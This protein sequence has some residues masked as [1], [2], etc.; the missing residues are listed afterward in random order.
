MAEAE[1]SIRT[2][3]DWIHELDEENEYL[4]TAL[5]DAAVHREQELTISRNFA[6][7]F[8]TQEEEEETT[9]AVEPAIQKLKDAAKRE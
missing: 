1:D 2:M 5:D 4:R 7:E 6:V 3:T 9:A 8:E